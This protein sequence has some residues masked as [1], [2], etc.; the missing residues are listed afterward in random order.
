M[1]SSRRN[2]RASRSWP[3]VGAL[4]LLA[5]APE[6]LLAAEGGLFD[7]N[8]GLAVWVL[9]VFGILMLILRRFAWGPILAAVNAREERIRSALDGA[10]ETRSEAEALLA[11]QRE[12]LMAARK[13]AGEIVAEGRSAAEEVRAGIEAK[14]RAAADALVERAKAEIARERD[15]ALE[16]LRRESVDIALRAASHLLSERLDRESDRAVV[17]RYLSQIGASP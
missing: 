5:L 7:I 6:P 2:R 12:R 1:S 17:D 16:E 10:D 15:A 9:A 13:R 14:A 3:A 11:E 4:P 8:A